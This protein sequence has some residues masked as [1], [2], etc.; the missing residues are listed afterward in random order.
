MNEQ[1]V[2]K[3]CIINL[4]EFWIKKST[5]NENNNFLLLIQ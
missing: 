5:W 4:N 1:K 3:E 2:L